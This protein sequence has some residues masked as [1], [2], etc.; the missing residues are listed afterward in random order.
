VLY[1]GYYRIGYGEIRVKSFREKVT[2]LQ[3]Q[4]FKI[5]L[6]KNAANAI[7]IKNIGMPQFSGFA[8]ISKILMFLDP[9]KNVIL[10]KKIM[11]LK[12][13]MNPENPLSKIPYRDKIDTSIRITKVS[14][15]CYWKWCELCGFIAK[16][17]DD[18]RIA[19]DIERGFFKLVEVGKVDY[20]RKIIAYYVSKQGGKCNW[21]SAP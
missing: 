20:G 4:S 16:Q 18:K 3:L 11:A 2:E 6:Q 1:W 12:D 13:P 14:Q 17:L 9:T 19:V 15:E 10:D 7:N 21:R 5:L 8:F